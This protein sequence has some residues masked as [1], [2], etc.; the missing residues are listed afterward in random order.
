M[1]IHKPITAAIALL[2]LAAN[3]V[4]AQTTNENHTITPPSTSDWDIPSSAKEGDNVNIKYTGNKYVKS[5]KVVPRIESISIIYS[6]LTMLEGATVNL[7]C[8]VALFKNSV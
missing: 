5:V 8:K 6:C 4:W 7:A 2:L 1:K 3:P